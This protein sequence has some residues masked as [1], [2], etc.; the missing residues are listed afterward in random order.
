MLML[1]LRSTLIKVLRKR[2]RAFLP[3]LR[4]IHAS[5][6]DTHALPHLKRKI[7]AAMQC[8][9]RAR[10]FVYRKNRR[11]EAHIQSRKEE[12]DASKENSPSVGSG[13][14]AQMA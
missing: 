3:A 11:Y 8:L 2:R 14:N 10:K 5:E 9:K 6:P 1:T 13:E 4:F 7:E 12:S